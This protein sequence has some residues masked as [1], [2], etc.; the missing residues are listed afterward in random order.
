LTRGAAGDDARGAGLTASRRRPDALVRF[1]GRGAATLI[2]AL[3]VAVLLSLLGQSGS[4]FST[5]GVGAVFSN[6]WNVPAGI[7]QGLPLLAGTLMTAGIAV[8]LATPVAVGAALWTAELCPPRAVGR[9][10]VAIDALAAVPSVVWGL[11]GLLFLAPKLLGAERWFARTFAVIPWLGGG[12]SGAAQTNVFIGGLVLAIM[13]V[14][15]ICAISRDVIAAVPLPPREAARALGATRWETIRLVVLP[16]SRRG[17]AGAVLVGLVR[18]LGETIAVVLLIGDRP[19]IAPHLFWPGYS[20][21]AA[22]A[23][24]LGSAAGPHRASLFAAGLVLFSL[25]GLISLAASALTRGGP[26]PRGLTPGGLTRGRPSP[27][28]LTPSGPSAPA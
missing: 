1:G 19:A 10:S 3:L 25:C 4:A 5:F 21:A 12:A 24:E 22:I 23:N 7:F 15:V 6:N 13:I 9:L 8:I 28:T 14:P 27:S 16:A 17:I 11:W 26:A 20:L 2:L 18:A